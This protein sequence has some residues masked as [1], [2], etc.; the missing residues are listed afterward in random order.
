MN[1][2][3]ITKTIKAKSLKEAIKRETKAE[4]VDVLKEEKKDYGGAHAIGFAYE[5]PLEEE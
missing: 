2:Y 3:I 4:I 5:E 1:K